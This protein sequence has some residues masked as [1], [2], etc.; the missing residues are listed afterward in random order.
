M[1][2]AEQLFYSTLKIKGILFKVF[3]SHKG[4][5]KIYINDIGTKIK[6]GEAIKLHPDDPYMNNV[7]KQLKEYFN[8]ERKEFDIPLDLRGTDFQKEVWKELTKIPYGKTISYKELAIKMGGAAKSRAV[9]Q[10][11]SLNPTP[12]VV[13]CHRVINTDGKLGGYSCGLDVK[14]MLLE[15]EGKLSLELFEEV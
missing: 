5:L 3:A 6:R 2:E 14:E 8:M 11:N 1:K 15:L 10:A 13:P 9:G 12:I 7:F 4:I